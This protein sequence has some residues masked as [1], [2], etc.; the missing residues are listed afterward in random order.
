MCCNLHG[1]KRP[2]ESVYTSELLEYAASIKISYIRGDGMWNTKQRQECYL[3][4]IKA[5]GEY[6]G[7]NNL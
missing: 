4:F 5:F 7:V 2:A 6:L 1:I 3:L